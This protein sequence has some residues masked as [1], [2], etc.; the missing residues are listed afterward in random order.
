MNER[1]RTSFSV[2][3]KADDGNIVEGTFTAKRLSI[4]DRSQM[5]L[6]KSQLS[7]GMYCVRDDNGNPT[8]QG[9]DDDTDYLNAMLAHLEVALIQ[10]P[11]W[12]KLDDIVDI[13]ILREVYGKVAA[14]EASFFRRADGEAGSGSGLVGA[15][16]SSQ[17]PPANGSGNLPTP[18]VGSQVQAALDA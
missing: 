1:N 9:L 3:F 14:F 5:G 13:G 6:R 11:T 10:K 16:D 17:Q 7:G 18:V 4:K 8:G 2:K 12:W 15:A